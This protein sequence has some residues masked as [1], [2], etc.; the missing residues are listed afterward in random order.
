MLITFSI[1]PVGWPIG[2]KVT[3]ENA[4]EAAPEG[5]RVDIGLQDGDPVAITIRNTGAVPVAIRTR[6]FDKYVTAGKDG[7]TG[8]GT[9][10]AKLLTEAQGGSIQLA[11][12]DAENR[13]ELTVLLP[14]AV[15]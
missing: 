4:C 11:V 2:G 7:G 1:L 6:F 13:T 15:G 12:Q 5:S 3:A 14:C 10:S 9:Y 8:I